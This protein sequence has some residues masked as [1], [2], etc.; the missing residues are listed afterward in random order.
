[1]VAKRDSSDDA[2]EE[3]SRESLQAVD[4]G[5]GLSGK[6]MLITPK[7]AARWLLQLHPEQRNVAP[8]RVSGIARDMLS[9]AFILTHQAV[10]WDGAGYVIDGQHRLRA[11]CESNKSV[12]MLVIWNKTAAFKDPIDRN[13]PRSLGFIAKRSNREVATLTCLRDMEVGYEIKN[14]MTV[15]DTIDLWDKHG[16]VIE[17]VHTGSTSVK[18]AVGGMLAAYV[19]AYPIDPVK[20]C[21]FASKVTTGEMIKRGDPPFALR[22]WRESQVA[23]SITSWRTAMA[24]LGCLRAFIKGE[25][26]TSIHPDASAGYRFITGKRRALKIPNTP[27]PDVVPSVG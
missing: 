22:R 19:W 6:V 25:S 3:D 15:N 27:G 16:S 2:F 20:V 4:L 12:Y 11:V 8:G 1:M 17:L 13:L 21:D 7:I 14:P 26:I 10:A 23:Y 24:T 9:D 18:G 5:R